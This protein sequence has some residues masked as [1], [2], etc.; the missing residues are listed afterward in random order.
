M[1]KAKIAAK[2]VL[3][4]L[5]VLCALA[6]RPASRPANAQQTTAPPDAAPSPAKARNAPATSAQ[7]ASTQGLRCLVKAYPDW[8]TAAEGN[9]VIWRDGTRMTYDDGQT[10]PDWETTLN[11]ASLADQMTQC[12]APGRKF[13]Q[14]IP[15]DYDPG[16]ARHEAF[17]LKMYGASAAEVQKK[18][19][20]VIWLPR[21]LN[22]KLMVSSVNGIAGKL[23]AVS[24]ELDKLPD[25]FL[26]YFQNPGGTF[27]WRNIAGTTRLSTHSFG[28][29]IDI[30]VKLSDYW[31]N[32]KPDANGK[33][34]YRN[35]IPLEIVEIFER[36]GFIWGGKWYHYDTMHFEYRPELLVDEC[37]CKAT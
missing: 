11:R 2:Y 18:L 30:N 36:H 16:R 27:N 35:K 12:Y 21:H 20:P 15:P 37:T 23:Q 33:Y 19:V 7:T 28:A 9:A 6:C 29:T 31:R 10:K 5:A 13:Q 26:P 22:Q 3:L 25:E 34:A 17:F 1:N 32:D 8:L 4:S 14:P 24:D